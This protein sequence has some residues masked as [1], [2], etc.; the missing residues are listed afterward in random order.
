MSKVTQVQELILIRHATTD[1]TGTFCGQSDPPLNAAG[2]AQACDLA[3]QLK[4]CNVGRLYASNLRRAVET[5]EPLAEAWCI[6]VTTLAALREIS[7]G[8]WEGK[9]WSQIRA[10]KPDI[11]AM[12]SSPELSAPGGETFESFHGRVLRVLRKV[13][14]ECNGHLTAVVTHLGV[15]RILLKELSTPDCSWDSHQRIEPCAVYKVR[16][17][18]AA[19]T[20]GGPR[21]TSAEM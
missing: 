3:E 15:L 4:D 18:S 2:R 1:M 8:E 10:D 13:I 7:F 16:V 19:I 9:C 17:P 20:S 21:I 12:E 6:P 11:R 5:A 14:L